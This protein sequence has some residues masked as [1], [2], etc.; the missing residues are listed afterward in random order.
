MQTEIH[1]L[2]KINS[3]AAPLSGSNGTEMDPVLAFAATVGA[4]ECSRVLNRVVQYQRGEAELETSLSFT[5]INALVVAFVRFFKMVDAAKW[6]VTSWRALAL[7][8]VLMALPMLFTNWLFMLM[9]TAGFCMCVSGI[10]TIA[11]SSTIRKVETMLEKSDHIAGLWKRGA[12]MFID[13]P[14][15][16]LRVAAQMPTINQEMV[17]LYMPAKKVERVTDEGRCICM[18]AIKEGDIVRSPICGHTFHADCLDPWLQRKPTCPNCRLFVGPFFSP[19]APRNGVETT[20]LRPPSPV[21]PSTPH[22]SPLTRAANQ[23]DT[24]SSDSESDSEDAAHDSERAARDPVGNGTDS[25][26]E[27]DSETS[28]ATPRLRIRTATQAE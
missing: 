28:N 4:T 6:L 12:N 25:E 3:C 2:E 10:V 7:G 20:D 24:D 26:T 19:N 18:E 16:S 9:W 13:Y 1:T 14:G 15:L 11:T 21:Q 17:D 8:S 5:V 27:S 23:L 22:M